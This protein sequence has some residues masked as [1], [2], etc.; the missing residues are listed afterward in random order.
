VGHELDQGI[1]GAQPPCGHERL[2][3]TDVGFREEHLSLKIGNVDVV[4]IDDFDPTDPGGGEIE[5]CRAAESAR[6][7]H[8]HGTALQFRLC[9]RAKTG[10]RKMALVAGDFLGSEVHVRGQALFCE[11]NRRGPDVSF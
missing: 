6:P 7:E 3:L 4:R 9:L 11:I 5:Q 2:R 10:E 1:Q 8:Q